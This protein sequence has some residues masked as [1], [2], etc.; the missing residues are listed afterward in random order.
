MMAR[1]FKTADSYTTWVNQAQGRL[2]IISVIEFKGE[3][4]VTYKRH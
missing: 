3:I 2:E 1:Q 4:V